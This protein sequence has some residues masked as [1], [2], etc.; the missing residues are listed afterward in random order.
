MFPPGKAALHF[1]PFQWRLGV[2]PLLVASMIRTFTWEPSYLCPKAAASST[3]RGLVPRVR[4]RCA[5]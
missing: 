3:F 2:Q 4:H 5:R 1:E